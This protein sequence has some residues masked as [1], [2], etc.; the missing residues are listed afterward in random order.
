MTGPTGPTGVGLAGP[1]GPQGIQGPSGN[2]TVL[3]LKTADQAISNNTALQNDSHL[4]H[5]MAANESWEFDGL[6]LAVA[7]SDT[8]DIKV[9]IS[10]PSG[11]TLAW[12]G[13]WIN[14]T[15]NTQL[16]GTSGI[17][18]TPRITT[19]GFAYEFAIIGGNNGGTL[20]LQGIVMNGAN[21][22]NL[23]VQWAQTNSSAF[24]TTMQR[25]SY[26][27]VSKHN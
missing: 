4:F 23:Q 9:A 6:L 5:P 19:S 14:Q 1:T 18:M 17:E 20:R 12:V 8:P 13:I 15:P 16:P 7:N 11:A 10:V 21:A 3:L 22:G 26:I 25:G 2:S 24:A 27:R